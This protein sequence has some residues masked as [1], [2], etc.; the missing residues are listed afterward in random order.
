MNQAEDSTGE[1]EQ[2]QVQPEQTE[3]APHH[4]GDTTLHLRNELARYLQN[5]QGLVSQVSC[6]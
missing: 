3:P 2:L 6:S 4:A 1:A 5:L